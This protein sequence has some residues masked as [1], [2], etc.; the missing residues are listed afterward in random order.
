MS[1]GILLNHHVNTVKDITIL[2]GTTLYGDLVGANLAKY[3]SGN[4][5]GT[6][7]TWDAG[8]KTALNTYS[9]NCYMW[10]ELDKPVNLTKFKT[11]EFTVNM[12]QN[13]QSSSPGSYNYYCGVSATSGASLTNSV[14]YSGNTTG[15][16]TLDI[17]SLS[18]SYY[19]KVEHFV[20]GW[21]R[22]ARLTKVRLLTT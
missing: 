7:Y 13:S 5:S 12:N 10:V 17:S 14:A 9:G 2:D 4:I 21:G 3:Q 6:T 22:Q 16:K 15:V 1:V 18:G 19:I 20:N 8:I 11:I